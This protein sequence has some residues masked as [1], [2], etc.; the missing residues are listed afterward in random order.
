MQTGDANLHIV[1]FEESDLVVD[2]RRPTFSPTDFGGT[3]PQ[4]GDLI[5]LPAGPQESDRDLAENHRIR[6]VIE[7]YFWPSGDPQIPTRVGLVVRERSSRKSLQRRA[8][9]TTRAVARASTAADIPFIIQQIQTCLRAAKEC[10]DPE[11]AAALMR[12]A[13]AFADRA[14]ALGA[15]PKTIPRAVPQRSP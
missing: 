5:A 11:M 14:I 2:E 6:E 10:N 1:I 8:V 12:L 13:E 15:D 4:V 7:R 9:T 3:I